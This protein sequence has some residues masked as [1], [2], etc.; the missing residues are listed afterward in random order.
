MNSFRRWTL[1]LTVLS[2][3]AWGCR[4]DNSS[5]LVRLDNRDSITVDEYRL[6]MQ[7]RQAASSLSFEEK[8]AMVI[9][10]VDQHLKALTAVEENLHSDE[11][12]ADRLRSMEERELSAYAHEQ[13]LVS[14]FVNDS[15]V[16]RFR[17][18]YG[19]EVSVQNIVVRY[20]DFAGSNATRTKENARKL[21][22]SVYA[23]ARDTS[24]TH[25]AEAVS[26]FKDPK[27]NKGFSRTERF[28]YGSLP[29][30]YE[31]AVFE[32]GP[33]RILPPIDLPGAFLIPYVREFSKDSLAKLMSN[34]DIRKL[35]RGR[36]DNLDRPIYMRQLMRFT[37]PLY[38]SASVVMHDAAIDTLIQK[39]PAGVQP[40]QAL[41]QFTSQNL[42]LPVTTFAGKSLTI[43][44]LL[45]TKASVFSMARP[46]KTVVVE[47]I[48][49]VVRE[50]LLLDL[51]RRD[52]LD[53][54]STYRARV[55]L[56][57]SEFLAGKAS[58]RRIRMTDSIRS[59]DLRRYYE[60]HLDQFRTP[61]HAKVLELT[62]TAKPDIDQ[63]A[64]LVKAGVPFEKVVDSVRTLKGGTTTLRMKSVANMTANQKN[65]LSAVAL[66]LEQDGISEVISLKEGGFSILKVIEKRETMRQP[67]ETVRRRVETQ[68]RNEMKAQAEARW[69]ND[70]KRKMNIVVYEGLIP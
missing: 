59:A 13:Y 46:E 24:F 47:M 63:A 48:G 22:D 28:K 67:F 38:Q 33:G 44:D 1:F 54:S 18:N 41:S 3:S 10:L 57:R 35:L 8:R 16:A 9:S 21:A 36:L 26:D 45:T 60:D 7:N 70:M 25:L 69:L 55:S 58:E 61:A 42:E 19:R 53:E 43:R 20:I 37:D 52:S 68:Y 23:V 56:K 14:H 65:E 27:S 64:L 50:E 34:D 62:A 29:L 31:V 32:A 49:N 40:R 51:A 2:A 66:G 30:D 5:L 12:T 15:T 11:E 4:Q 39:Y 6:F 17:S